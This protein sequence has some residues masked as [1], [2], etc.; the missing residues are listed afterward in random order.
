MRKLIALAG[1]LSLITIGA[2]QAQSATT[3]HEMQ[4]FARQFM[5]AYNAQDCAALQQMYTEDAV[6]IDL[7]GK[8]IVG[9]DKIAAFFSEQFRLNDATLLIRQNNISWSDSQHT[10]LAHGDFEIYGKTIVYDIPIQLAGSYTN[11]MIKQDGKWKI[12]RSVLTP[13]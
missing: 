5:A 10:W 4:A 7:N 13:L 2:L 1:F 6:R 3:A 12:S 8:E 9:N 11:S